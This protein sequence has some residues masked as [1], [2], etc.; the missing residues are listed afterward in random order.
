MDAV[1][2]I[3]SITAEVLHRLADG[4]QPHR[5]APQQPSIHIEAVHIHCD[6]AIPETTKGV[7][8]GIKARFS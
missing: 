4:I 3:V 2:S 1:G 5:E 8:D 6:S 7:L